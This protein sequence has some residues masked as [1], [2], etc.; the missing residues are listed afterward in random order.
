MTFCTK[1]G[2]KRAG[3]ERFCTACGALLPEIADQTGTAPPG[4]DPAGT[5]LAGVA[6]AVE[7]AGTV[8]AEAPSGVDPA[9]TVLA[10]APSGVEPAGTVLAGVADAVEPAGT[11]LAE[12]PSGVDP[13]G[14]VLAEVPSAVDPTGTVLAEAPSGVDPT[15]TVLA[16]APAPVAGGTAPGGTGVTP[17]DSHT[18][19]VAALPYVATPGSM[20]G[21]MPGPVPGPMPGPVPGLMPGS[22]PG[23]VGPPGWLPPAPPRAGRD[24]SAIVIV[25]VAVVVVAAAGVFAWLKFGK[26]S[27]T[28]NQPGAASTRT[29]TGRPGTTPASISPT[30]SASVP[31]VTPTQ[32][33]PVSTLVPLGPGVASDAKTAAVD[34]FVTKYF[35]AINHHDYYQYLSLLSPANRQNETMQKFDSGFSSTT[36]SQEMITSIVNYGSGVTGAALSFVSH[37]LPSQSA[38]NSSCTEW[39]ITLFLKRSGG[40][41]YIGPSQPGYQAQYS[42]C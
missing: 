26:H 28:G 15:G 22:M 24:W 9:G 31:S 21:A 35:A 18:V 20:P 16:E 12:V 7:P 4:V 33:S 19:S 5:D 13:T 17:G 10:E 38:T 1:C 23:Q 2:R 29:V 39:D 30:P 42:A 34:A 8:L 6:D 37:Q 32:T 40:R 27:S 36:D 14:T 41:Y 25:T 11:V 3:Q